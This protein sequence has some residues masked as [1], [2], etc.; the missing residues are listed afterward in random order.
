MTGIGAISPYG[1]GWETLLEGLTASRSGI[2]PISSADNPLD[3]VPM[4]GR[5]SVPLDMEPPAGFRISR[6]DRLGLVAAREAGASLAA[7]ED[8]RRECAVVVSTTVG[9]LSDID[10]GAMREPARYYR[11]GGLGTTSTYPVSHVA[12]CVAADLGLGGPRLGLS[13]A[14]AQHEAAPPIA[15]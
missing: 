10:P 12:D 9:G 5:V 6:T 4:V 14:C 15:L 7:R 8:D 13:V 3:S 2:S 11:S 1:Q